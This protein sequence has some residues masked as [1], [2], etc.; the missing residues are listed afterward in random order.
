MTKY[1]GAIDSGTT[2][3]RFM[4]FDHSG[5]V[6]AYAQREHQQI[7]PQSGWVEHDAREIW[8]RTREVI[9]AT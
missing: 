5:A 9:G 4:L 7:F 8:E 6:L 2:S 3:T 1:V